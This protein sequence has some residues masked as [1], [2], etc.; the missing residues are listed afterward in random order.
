LRALA[1]KG[2]STA[3]G[4]ARGGD[5]ALAIEVF[6]S[7]RL[8]LL[9]RDDRNGYLKKDLR[10]GADGGGEG[11]NAR[12]VRES[13]RMLFVGI[14][15]PYTPD[16]RVLLYDVVVAACSGRG[17]IGDAGS[18]RRGP[19]EKLSFACRPFLLAK[20]VN[21]ASSCSTTEIGSEDANCVDSVVKAM[22]ISESSS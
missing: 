6:D 17:G 21:L 16:E 20:S 13:L 22:P 11:A 7:L 5:V 18:R 9:R 12:P 15:A 3:R 1:L 14:A 2:G 19:L 8:E 10:F 4:E